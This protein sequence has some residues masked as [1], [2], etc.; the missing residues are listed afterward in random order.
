[1]REH[2]PLPDRRAIAVGDLAVRPQGDVYTISSLIEVPDSWLTIE[3]R[4][5]WPSA[6]RKAYWYA[7]FK[8]AQLW[9]SRDSMTLELVDA[10]RV[11]L[12]A[13]RRWWPLERDAV[14]RH[15]PAEPGIYMLRAATPVFVG[16][17]DDLQGRLSYHLAH[18]L[19]CQE[20]AR[21]LLFSFQT[22]TGQQRAARAAELVLWWAPPCNEIS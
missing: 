1:M 10:E 15:A 16:D 11:W 13:S 9:T 6:V 3:T 14:A 17:T 18:P 8:N 2:D 21:A 20:A 22:M 5:S 4:S 19:S 7:L 12:A